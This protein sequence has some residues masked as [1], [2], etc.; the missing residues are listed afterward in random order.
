MINLTRHYGSYGREPLEFH[1]LDE[2]FKYWR[3]VM[4]PRTGLGMPL[5]TECQLV[6][7]RDALQR[8][9]E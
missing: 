2:A 8:C 4:W 6:F 3:Q 1:N 5:E 7:E 9:I